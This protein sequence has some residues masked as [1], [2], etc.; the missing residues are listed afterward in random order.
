MSMVIR[1]EADRP[2]VPTPEDVRCAG[3]AAE[4]LCAEYPEF[5]QRCVC[6]DACRDKNR[7]DEL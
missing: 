4:G 6:R 1:V 3:W 2:A 5:M 7:R